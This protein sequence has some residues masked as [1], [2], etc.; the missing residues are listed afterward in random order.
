MITKSKISYLKSLNTK[1]QRDADGVFTVE[2]EKASLE[3]LKSSM[4]IKEIFYTSEFSLK[5]DP[6]IESY[7]ISSEL[8]QRI[9]SLRSA[10]SVLMVVYKPENGACGEICSDNL[11]LLLDGVQD[12]GNLGTIIRVADWFGVK[13]IYCSEDCAD[14]YNQKVIQSTMGSITRIEVFYTNLVNLV[15]KFNNIPVYG[16]FLDGESI[17]TKPLTNNG[18]IIMGSEGRGISKELESYVTH[19][20]LIPSY[21][22]DAATVESLNVGVATAITLSVFRNN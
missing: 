21:P 19:K 2:T 3:V 22:E 14:V 9:S 11:T 15:K 12:P 8:M 16:T 4:K 18:I 13:R 5:F 7:L 10:S 20:L 6:S 1:K 17:Y